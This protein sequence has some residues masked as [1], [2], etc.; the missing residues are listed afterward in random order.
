MVFVSCDPF[1]S[2]FLFCALSPSVYVLHVCKCLYVQVEVHVICILYCCPQHLSLNWRMLA[3][4]AIQAGQQFIG[5][6]LS[7]S[8]VLALQTHTAMPRFLH[9]FRELI[10]TKFPEEILAVELDFHGWT[11]VEGIFYILI[12]CFRSILQTELK[13]TVFCEQSHRIGFC[14]IHQDSGVVFLFAQVLMIT[15]KSAFTH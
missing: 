4:S 10:N 6:L 2:L 15:S 7:P 12:L 8:I 11:K 1:I 14:V 9:R 5:I 3:L 13:D